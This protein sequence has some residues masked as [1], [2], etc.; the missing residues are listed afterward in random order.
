MY[1]RIQIASAAGG[2]AAAAEIIKK[3]FS[4]R[5]I[6]TSDGGYKIELDIGA[7]PG[8]G[9]FEISGTEGGVRI[10]SSS[11]IGVLHGAGYFMR[12]CFWDDGCFEPCTF[13]GIK[14][15]ECPIRSIYLAHHF[16]NYYHAADTARLGQYLE[17]MALW[18]INGIHLNVAEIDIESEESDE[19]V[20]ELEKISGVFIHAKSIGMTTSTGLLVNQVFKKFPPEYTFTPVGDPLGRHGNTGNIICL[21]V[22]GAQE[23]VDSLNR[24]MLLAYRANGAEID[25]VRTW[26]YDEGG[27]GCDKCAPGGNWG[28]NGYIAGAKSAFRTAREIYPGVKRVL[29]TWTFDTPPCGEWEELARSLHDGKDGEKWCDVILADSHGDFPRYPLE[30]GVPGDLPMISFPEISMW[31]L[32]PWGGWGANPLPARFTRLWRQTLHR[33]AGESAYS[34][35]IY[36]DINK[37]VIAN[38]TWCYEADPDETL[39]QYARYELGMKNDTAS[40]IRLIS[41]IEKTHTAAADGRCD[42]AD[43]DE[44][45]AVAAAID[46]SLPEWGRKSWRWRIVYLRAL[47][48]SRRYRLAAEKEGV[49]YKRLLSGDRSCQDAFA[50]LIEIFLCEKEYS[51]DPY[52]CRV[53]PLTD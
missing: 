23:Y 1:N 42:I 46:E 31:G 7:V 16:R 50:E 38:L 49:D 40:F 34:E 6:A 8:E 41:L 52:H 45:F 11:V 24:H 22:P 13:R 26:P 47:L 43:S 27:C 9:G 4:E 3:R 39:A 51:G 33:I 2:L 12:G 15:P 44:A 19:L 48:D 14:I 53:R 5:G 30:N 18:G 37:C 36:E 28:G 17:D 29:S 10:S 25:F 35:G 21:S 20:S 32:Y